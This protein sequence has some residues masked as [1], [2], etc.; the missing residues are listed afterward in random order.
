VFNWTRDFCPSSSLPSNFLFFWVHVA[1]CRSCQKTNPAAPVTCQIFGNESRGS[2]AQE[3][4]SQLGFSPFHPEVTVIR[5]LLLQSRG[6]PGD[7]R[8]HGD[9]PRRQGAW[10]YRGERLAA[11]GLL[12]TSILGDAITVHLTPFSLVA[13]PS[14]CVLCQNPRP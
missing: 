14:G 5:R 8:C 3:G 12:L 9:A 11:G 1:L 6:H 7:Q 2:G 10:L 4:Q 13:C